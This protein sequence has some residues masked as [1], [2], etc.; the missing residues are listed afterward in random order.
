MN[1]LIIHQNFPGQFLHVALAALSRPGI[2]VTAIGR[3]TA[4]GVYGI[5]LFR[6]HS[7]RKTSSY[8]HPYLHKYEEAILDGQQV[9][10]VLIRLKQKGYRPDVILGHP[11]WGETLFVKDVYPEIPLIHFCEYYYHSKG[12]DMDFDPE[13]PCA[14]DA[15]SRLRLLNSMHL[16]NLEQCDIGISP[17]HWQRS[18]FPTT[19]QSKI[20]VVHEGVRLQ[21][22]GPVAV[23]SVKLPS[24]HVIKA[25]QS[26]VTYVARNLEPYRGFHSFMRSIPYIQAEC[27]DAKIVIVGGDGVSY[28]RMPLGYESWRSKLL[29]ELNVD[30][31]RVHFTGKLPYATY[32]AILQVSKVHVYLTYPFVLS[33]SLLEAMASGCVVIGSDTA[34]VQEVIVDGENGLLVDFFD[35]EAI[36][37]KVCSV[38][39]TPEGF[40]LIKRSAESTAS[41]FDVK[42]GLKG[43]FDIF[44]RVAAGRDYK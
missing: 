39:E 11:G 44:D 3:D 32:R 20:Q 18:L 29:A 23:A 27:P 41:R 17:T 35:S 28:G 14:V 21:S 12:A 2:V 37:G 42:H 13:F 38:L 43:Y 22:P 40:D 16:L 36:A 9:L 5:R 31:S 6:Y 4:S 30:L 33:W 34:P 15:S 24:G 26:V 8:G 25:G 10:G 19:Y 1:L 7:I